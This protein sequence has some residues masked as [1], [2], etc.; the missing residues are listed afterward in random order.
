MSSMTRGLN[1]CDSD[2]SGFDWRRSSRSY[3]WGNCVEVAAPNRERVH[4]RDSKDAHGAILRFSLTQWSA[5]A[6]N[7]RNG[8]FGSCAA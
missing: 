6:E 8:C 1:V 2:D 4:V 3:G 7:V 5:F